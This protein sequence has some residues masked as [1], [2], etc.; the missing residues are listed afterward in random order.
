MD[1]VLA[2]HDRRRNTFKQTVPEKSRP[3]C[4]A[5]RIRAAR[6]SMGVIETADSKCPWF[7]EMRRRPLELLPDSLRM[8]L[9]PE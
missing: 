2:A 7:V 4:E 9:P 5:L 8:A 3:E 6:Y 1:P